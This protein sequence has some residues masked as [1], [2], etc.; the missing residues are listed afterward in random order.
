MGEKIRPGGTSDEKEVCLRKEV[1]QRQYLELVSVKESIGQFTAVMRTLHASRDDAA[2]GDRG[3]G[4]DDV[5]RPEEAARGN[6]PDG[7]G[8][9]WTTQPPILSARE[10]GPRTKTDVEC[11]K[12]DIFCALVTR[13]RSIR[14]TDGAYQSVGLII[15][16]QNSKAK[17]ERSHY[18]RRNASRM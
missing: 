18:G 14:G 2:V 16:Y 1:V 11:D 5:N 13:L 15:M 9:P 3:F 8:P 12:D 7:E 6:D 10:V 4:S 17:R